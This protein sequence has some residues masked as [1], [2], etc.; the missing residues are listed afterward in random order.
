MLLSQLQKAVKDSALEAS[1]ALSLVARMD[2]VLGLDLVNSAE[3]VL[4]SM[5][6]ASSAAS[7]NTHEGDPEAELIDRLVAERVAA[8]K[9]KD[10]AKADSIRDQL[11]A[12]G[13]V[14]TDT[15]QGPVWERK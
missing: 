14:V 3:Q 10:F 6:A 15:P 2:T 8:K 4:G 5:Q 9:A 12:K 13:I 7:V 1:E 11:T